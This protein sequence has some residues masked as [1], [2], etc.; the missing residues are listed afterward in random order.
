MKNYED[1]V[2]QAQ[3]AH[4]QK[5]EA[6]ANKLK[7]QMQQ[8]EEKRLRDH[9][10]TKTEKR[11]NYDNLQVRMRNKDR[12]TKSGILITMRRF[13]GG[14]ATPNTTTNSLHLEWKKS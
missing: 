5:R 4:F 3:Q 8:N 1:S 9:R 7:S 14:V 12:R 13:R 2:S 6:Y 11:F 10:M